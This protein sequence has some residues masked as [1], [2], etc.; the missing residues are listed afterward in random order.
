MDEGVGLGV[1]NLD[2][3][4]W[5]WFWFEFVFAFVYGSFGVDE[6]FCFVV[7]CVSY[8]GAR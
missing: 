8:H 2:F 6:M 3:G 7:V 5:I 4:F 1:W